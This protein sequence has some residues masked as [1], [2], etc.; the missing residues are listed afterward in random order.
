MKKIQIKSLHF[1]VS[2]FSF[3]TASLLNVGSIS[4]QIEHLKY[5][6]HLGFS[7]FDTSPYYGFGIAETVLGKA[8]KNNPNV[9]I[10]SKVGIYPPKLISKQP[11]IYEVVGRK[12]VGKFLKKLNRPKIDFS[13][14]L[15]TL[16]VTK[17]L[18]N[19]NRKYLDILFIHEPGIELIN[20]DQLADWMEREK[21]RV[22]HFGF[23]GEIDNIEN[24]LS[25]FP[26]SRYIYQGPFIKNKNNFASITY[27]HFRDKI[28][29][30]NIF[31]LPVNDLYNSFLV[32]SSKKKRLENFAELG[33]KS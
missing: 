1:P 30:N 23:A 19:L 26:L 10:A 20:V 33:N 21:Y 17:T 3:G 29:G 9:T 16:S 7:H 31:Q 27:G 2:K 28:H 25:F 13:T 12:V 4:K 14:S 6:A 32:Y 5:A 24:F 8:F 22:K 18:K 15:A 11:N